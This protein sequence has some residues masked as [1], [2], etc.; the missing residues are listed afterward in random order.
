MLASEVDVGLF[1]NAD[2]IQQ[3]IEAAYATQQKTFSEHLLT[4]CVPKMER[5]R[6][7]FAG[8]PE[9]PAEFQTAME[10]YKKSLPGLQDG[11]QVYAERI[12]N[13]GATKDVDQLIQEI[14]NAWH[15]DSSPTPQSIAFDKFLRCAVPGL[16][17][18]K[19]A[20]A[21]IE[22]FA[23]TCFK[24]DPVSFMDRV[25]KDCGP[26]LENAAAAGAPAPGYKAR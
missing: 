13:R 2:Q 26:I 16:D 3:R 21:L 17:K 8:L 22:F 4:E 18:M 9:P 1:S 11:I 19:D 7:A 24:K 12:T 20:Q 5:A 10:T 15:T 23:D 14:G 25:R 6:Q